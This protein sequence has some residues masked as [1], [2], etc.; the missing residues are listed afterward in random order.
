MTEK[1]R[2]VEADVREAIER[3]ED[4]REKAMAVFLRGVSEMGLIPERDAGTL[5]RSWKD[6]PEEQKNRWLTC[7]RVLL[8]GTDRLAQEMLPRRIVK[9]VMAQIEAVPREGDS[10]QLEYD[11]GVM[12]AEVTRVLRQAGR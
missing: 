11:Y 3:G 8:V 2:E 12:V 1:N 4:E 10:A 7:A 6:L 5:P 9:V